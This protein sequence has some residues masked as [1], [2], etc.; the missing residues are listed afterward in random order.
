MHS[1]LDIQVNGKSLVIP[2]D[3]SL[4]AEEKNPLFN[5]VTFFSYPM[6]IP[7][8]GNREVLKNIAHRDSNMRA[9]D[10]EHADARIFADGLPLNSGQVITQDGSEIKDTFEFNID[11]QQQSFSELIGD[12]ECRD[13]DISEKHIVIGEKLGRM[14][15]TGSILFEELRNHYL[16]G[17]FKD[18]TV[19][20]AS[21]N[22]Q[23]EHTLES[24][25]ALGF[26]IYG[27][28]QGFPEAVRWRETGAPMITE[29]FTN[30]TEPYPTSPFCNVRAAYAHNDGDGG[31]VRGNSKGSDPEDYGQYWC[32]PAARQ[33]S[34]VC[35][36]V[37][38]FL[39]CLFEQLGVIFN[40]DELLAVEDLKRVFFYTTLCRYDEVSTNRKLRNGDIQKWLDSRD[41]GGKLGLTIHAG[42]A[43]R[44][45]EKYDDDGS[46]WLPREQGFSEL[47]ES[48][49]IPYGQP[50]DGSW[51]FHYMRYNADDDAHYV[52]HIHTNLD[53]ET[54]VVDMIANSDCFPDASVSSVI[55][56]LEASF[57][58][59]FLYDPEKRIVTA[60]LLR[61]IYKEQVL[62]SF[63]GK[64]LSMTP[65]NEKI[66]GVRVGYSAESDSKDQQK[67]VRYG[68][69]DYDTEFDYI[70]F[71]KD[72]TVTDKTYQQLVTEQD[73][74][75]NDNR[76]VYIDRQTGDC[77]RIKIDADATDTYSMHPV[78]FQVAQWKGIEEGDCSEKNKDYVR[79]LISEFK[80]LSQNIIN[81]RDYNNDTVGAVA[82]I[83]APYL[84]VDMERELS[85]QRI[86]SSIQG[87]KIP[88]NATCAFDDDVTLALSETLKLRE[89]YDP[90]QTDTGNSPL[91]D[92]DW[93]L[94][95][96][97]MRGGGNNAG[98]E[99]YQQNYDG[100]G[101][102]KWRHTVGTYAVYSDCLTQKGEPFD[103][104]GQ[105][106]GLGGE[107]F[108]LQIRSW[109]QPSWADA[110]II[111][112]DKEVMN[113]GLYDTFLHPH[114]YFLLHRKPYKVKVL[115]TMA[116]LL[117]IRNHWSDKFVIDGKVG[118]INAIKYNI[119]K[120]TGVSE[121]E[122]EFYSL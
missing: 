48:Y 39:D 43:K 55:K 22:D 89:S 19:L 72:R 117:D 28:T 61:N 105:D 69:K 88:D 79:E 93:G 58:I 9:M 17:D 6:Q 5:D 75:T 97:I 57:G 31:T 4:S 24:P 47:D 51:V 7:V 40:K 8:G 62:R 54:E 59:R 66:T 27:R 70:D 120:A 74:I 13:V 52:R 104:N 33:Q 116:Q 35:F 110:P 3:S 32:L 68:I 42:H 122:L 41:C 60:R 64:V 18:Q 87:I 112:A 100:F 111:I 73:I 90:T 71:P 115:A 44:G 37:L 20:W 84:D 23:F 15:V 25:Q 77:Y 102:D 108:S 96:G 119:E 49:E 30:V 86:E 106:E 113:R 10:L 95:I 101:N 12:M 91:Q 29:D 103:Y 98:I 50:Y 36:Y 45:R 92:L 107:H 76:R 63:N 109:Q 21:R 85:E 81:A 16:D 94:T 56:S 53:V 14:K 78:L 46:G 114:A 34:G 38:F 80:P 26:S 2:E 99:N 83:L 82:P 1:H 118:W 121:A 67:N 11:A 65:V